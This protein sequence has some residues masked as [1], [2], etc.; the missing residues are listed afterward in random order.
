MSAKN[1]ATPTTSD[2]ALKPL[3]GIVGT[4]TTEATHPALGSSGAPCRIST[5]RCSET[6]SSTSVI[7]LRLVCTRPSDY[8]NPIEPFGSGGERIVV[9]ILAA[10]GAGEGGRLAPVISSGGR[11]K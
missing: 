7:D 5:P 10:I 3:D 6:P 1:E 8:A 4:W 2:P 11:P 9:A